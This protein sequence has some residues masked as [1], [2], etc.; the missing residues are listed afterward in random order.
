MK[1]LAPIVLLLFFLPAVKAGFYELEPGETYTCLTNQTVHCS[2]QA[3]DCSQYI[4]NNISS[5]FNAILESIQSVESNMSYCMILTEN[6]T[7]CTEALAEQRSLAD[8]HL[9]T[10]DSLTNE[11]KECKDSKDNM[12][13][14]EQY[15]SLKTERDKLQTKYESCQELNKEYEDSKLV[16]P[17]VAAV[18]GFGLAWFFF[19]KRVSVKKSI[20]THPGRSG[21]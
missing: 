7:N 12:Y 3:V 1:K 8:T 18:A 2:E 20:E 9:N 10:I 17:A 11:L 14:S 6:Y 16:Y 4:I 5:K 21:I 13:T 19:H 15:L